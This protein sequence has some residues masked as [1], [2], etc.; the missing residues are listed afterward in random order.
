MPRIDG[1]T[2][3]SK[4]RSLDSDAVILF[5]SAK[6]EYVFDAIKVQPFRFIRKSH[7]QSDLSE[8]LEE[9]LCQNKTEKDNHILTL[10]IQ[11]EIYRFSVQDIIYIQ[12]KD[13][14]LDIVTNKNHV[15]IRYKISDMEKLLESYQFLRIHKSYL[16]NYRYIYTLQNKTVTLENGMTLPVSRYRLSEVQTKFK[17]YIYDA[18][19]SDNV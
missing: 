7:F 12:A 17:E 11:N 14:Y 10:E 6:E 9:Y 18:V 15:L 1:L 4:I 8:A 13:N 19:Q 16:V 5:V 3:A 2:L